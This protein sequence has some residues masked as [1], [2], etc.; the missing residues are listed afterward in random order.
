[1]KDRDVDP[2]S[3]ERPYPHYSNGAKYVEKILRK[4]KYWHNQLRKAFS[5][6]QNLLEKILRKDKYRQSQ[7][8]KA[9]W[10]THWTQIMQYTVTR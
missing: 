10:Y 2:P 5:T 7:L 4:E 6:G 3:F 8:R 9:F 1:M